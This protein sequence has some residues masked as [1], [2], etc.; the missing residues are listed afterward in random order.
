MLRKVTV[1]AAI[2][3]IFVFASSLFA[4]SIVEKIGTPPNPITV[5]YLKGSPYQMGFIHGRTLKNDIHA[6]YDSLLASVSQY[7]SL[8]L[9]DIAYRQLEPFIP[10]AY[11]DEM[12]G[13]ADGAEIDLQT[14]HRVHAIPDVSEMD[15][16][17]FAAWGKATTDGNLYQIRALDYATGW[18]LQ[19][20]PAILVCEPDSGRRF[21]NV[22]WVGFIGVVS[23][24][25]ADG[26]AVS[27]IGES[28]DKAHQTMAAEPMPFL[29]RD[30]LQYSGSLDSAVRRISTA[31][32]TSSF[33][34]CVGDSKIPAA[35][36]F[37][38]SPTVCD[39]YS[40]ST[41]PNPFL[42]DVVYF[43]MGVTSHWNADVY[44]FLQPRHGTIGVPTGI[45]L[46]RTLGTG[47]L[48]AV[49]YDP[50]HHKIWVA[51]A[52]V[53][54]TPAYKRAFWEYDLSRADSIFAHYTA[55]AVREKIQNVPRSVELLQN[56]PN[57]FNPS[58]RIEFVISSA[59]TGPLDLSVFDLTGRKIATLAAGFMKLGRYTR[60]WNGRN[61]RGERLPSG[62]YLLRLKD[63]HQTQIRRMVLLK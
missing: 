1:L 18:H 5:I 23:G 6:L 12:R 17:F 8:T 42:D 15:C 16:S 10:Q 4:G 2:F 27:E 46:M 32:R 49:V 20:H 31:H 53:D 37:K 44:H 62:I 51:N 56:Y 28:F 57:P 63:N 30:V 29:L 22:G 7:G 40:D 36:A 21:V 61:S 34:Y 25:N 35:R 33:L 47:S 59:Q 43:S 45:D 41:S 14:V 11:K 26:L 48:H 55:T 3:L 58:T 50:A 60:F 52:G 38:T 9:L 54:R 13:L 39:V 19:E 24:M